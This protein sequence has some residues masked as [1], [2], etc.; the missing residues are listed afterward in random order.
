MNPLF[1]NLTFFQDNIYPPFGNGMYHKI[2]FKNVH[3]GFGNLF[4][5]RRLILYFESDFKSVEMHFTI[6]GK[7]SAHSANFGKTISFES[8]QHNIIYA[9]QMGGKMEFS[10]ED[11]Q[12]LENPRHF[13][14][15]F[16]RKYNVIPNTIKN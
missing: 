10:G 14:T 3:I 7:S 13:S 12:I 8:Y 5:G 1:S 16:K 11:M 6:N 9:Y 15:A 4:L 2:C